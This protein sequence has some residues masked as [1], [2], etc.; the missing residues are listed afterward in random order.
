M[1]PPPTAHHLPARWRDRNYDDFVISRTGSI[2]LS[3]E[4]PVTWRAGEAPAWETLEATDAEAAWAAIERRDGTVWIGTSEGLRE[5]N[6]A[7]GAITARLL[8]PASAGYIFNWVRALYEDRA[9]TLWVGTHG[10]L[11][12][13]DPQAKPFGHVTVDPGQGGDGGDAAVS[14]VY[15]RRDTLWL[16]TFGNGLVRVDRRTGLVRRYRHD[17]SNR[18]SL[19]NGIVWSVLGA[20][21]GGIW[22]GTGAGLCRLDART[23][24]FTWHDLPV[25]GGSPSQPRVTDIVQEPS[26]VLWLTTSDG[27][28]RY[29]P[30]SG[31]A[32]GFLLPGPTPGST[33]HIAESVLPE[34][35]ATVW[36][37]M[38]SGELRRLDPRTGRVDRYVLLTDDAR[39][40]ASQAV[41]DIHRD[42]DGPLWVATGAGLSRFDPETRT[43]RHFFHRD[44]LPGSVVY[45]ILPDERGALWLGTNR[46]LS[47]FDPRGTGGS[48]FRNF[49]VADGLRNTEFNRHAAFVD[50]RGEFFLGGMSG[51]TSFVPERIREN[52]YVPPVVFTRIE[53]ANRERVTEHNPRGLRQL[54]LSYRD[55]SFS[56]ELAALSYTNPEQNRY[57]HFLEGFDKDWVD[58]GT[59][60]F[61]R[62]TNIPPGEYLLRVRGSNNDGAWNEGAVGLAL[63]IAPPYW[64]TAWFRLLLLAAI[65]GALAWAY[66]RR[67][68]RLLE[69]ERLR[70]R[71]AG[72]L[73][74]DLSSNL[75]GIAVMGEMIQGRT[76]FGDDERRELARITMTARRMVGDLRDIVWLVDP[77]RDRLDDLVLRMKDLAGTLVPDARVS[78]R[79]D[80]RLDSDR[81]STAFREVFLIYKEILHN[82][83]RHSGATDVSIQIKAADHRFVLRVEDNGVGFDPERPTNGFG[84]ASLRRRVDEIDGDLSITSRAGEGTRVE[85]RALVT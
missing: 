13:L 73:H 19:R 61:V 80:G 43:F 66:H 6:P 63:S 20:A 26:G 47:R 55:Y 69:I 58:A 44:G 54:R 62:Y 3:S 76:A 78:F 7:S 10:G 67:V 5:V 37:G 75:S 23:G 64:D 52:S 1:R 22:V 27:V 48:A 31:T 53:T 56:F 82:V 38:A 16:G 36:I 30:P 4:G 57:A 45:S 65:L 28:F 2:W 83:A 81:L 59:R 84:L 24:R 49:S 42:A 50:E 85:V 72:D 71:I 9:G 17:P 68:E 33:D 46:G 70:L 12:R 60:R 79:T 15:A 34:D 21:D 51:V 77:G 29:D 35:S 41:W 39:P 74:D 14:A 25:P 18:T 40:L 32:R 11:Y 8:E